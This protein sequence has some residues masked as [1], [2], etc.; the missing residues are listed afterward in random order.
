M[1]VVTHLIGMT[2]GNCYN[3]WMTCQHM[4]SWPNVWDVSQE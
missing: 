2:C 1:T 3:N 4:P